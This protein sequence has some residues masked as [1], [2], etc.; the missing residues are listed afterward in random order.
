MQ[1]IDI[2]EALAALNERVCALEGKSVA[3][4]KLITYQMIMFLAQNEELRPVWDDS[5]QTS[6]EKFRKMIKGSDDQSAVLLAALIDTLD[7]CKSRGLA[8]LNHSFPFAV[9]KGGI[10]D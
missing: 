8:D 4:E 3:F 7:R 10:E 2:N 5:I 9:I 6:I 1:L